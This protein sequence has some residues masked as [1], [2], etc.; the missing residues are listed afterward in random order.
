MN[1]DNNLSLT[2]ASAGIYTDF[3]GLTRLRGQAAEQTGEANK[4][5]AQQFEALFLQIMLKSM[6]DASQL[7]ESTDGD[8]TRFYQDMFD[9]Q[10]AIDMASGQGIGLAAVIER[11]LGGSTMAAPAL[12]QP[13]MPKAF[14]SVTEQNWQPGGEDDFIRDLWPQAVEVA[15]EIGIDPEVLIAQSALETGWG[16]KVMKDPQ[17]QSSLNLFGIKADDRWQGDHVKVATLEYRDGIAQQEMATFRSYASRAESMRDYV[18]FLKENPRYQQALDNAADADTF[19]A[20]LQSA[21][22]ATDP[23]Y[24]NKISAILQRDSFVQTVADLKMSPAAE[25]TGYSF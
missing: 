6:R 14:A 3:D 18:S 25:K 13:L 5:V 10:V 16:Q 11:Q 19:V 7:S 22:Y 20:K 21:G 23:A 15:A 9:K 1:T 2:T 17:G 4:E 24:A 8:Q 12:Q